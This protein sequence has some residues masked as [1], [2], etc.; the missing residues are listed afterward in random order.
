[1]ASIE[2]KENVRGISYK[3]TA[4]LGY[5]GDGT[6]L[7]KCT[8]FRPKSTSI[9]SQEKEAWKF[10][11]EY[12]N[13]LKNGYSHNGDKMTFEE[14]AIRWLEYKESEIT[15]GSF[16]GYTRMVNDKVI[17]HFKGY[18][19]NAINVMVIDEFYRSLVKEGYAK[20]TVKKYCIVVNGIFKWA[21]KKQVITTN[22]CIGT[23][24][25]KMK[26]KIEQV[27]FFNKEQAIAFLNSL[28]MVFEKPIKAHSR[29]D[30]TGKPYF[31]NDYVERVQLSLQ[32][33][34]FYNIAI[35]CGLRKSEILALHWSDIDMERK[36]LIVNKSV[37]KTKDGVEYKDPKTSSSKRKVI[38]TDDIIRLLKQHWLE[39]STLKLSLGDAWKGNGNIFI[40]DDGQLMGRTTSYQAFKKHL[41]RYN[42]WAET[43]N[44][45]L[46]DIQQKYEILPLIPLHGLRHSCAS[47]LNHLGVGYSEISKVLGHADTSTTI[48]IYMHSFDECIQ[49]AGDRMNEFIAMNL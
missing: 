22:P 21:M 49:V 10:A 26:K 35:S 11:D 12:E 13:S 47:I 37:T 19:I 33:R 24:T 16:E 43:M 46:S 23:D 39:Y 30:D 8:T 6:K 15:Y 36:T 25:P 9:K 5:E 48:D 4:Y 45:S 2:R 44:K 1:M 29:I 28:D 17:P 14:I 20:A 27:K 34:I 18:R 31:V 38:L 42:A 3:I 40:R 32:L 41:K 7:R